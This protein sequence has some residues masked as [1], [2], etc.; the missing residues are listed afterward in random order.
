M[1]HSEPILRSTKSRVV[2]V[3]F[4]L[5]RPLFETAKHLT[6]TATNLPLPFQ[7]ERMASSQ[8]Q[9]ISFASL[10]A[11]IHQ[12]IAA[13]LP[14]HSLM[15]LGGASRWCH[16]FF[17]PLATGRLE[18]TDMPLRD[19]CI[20][21]WGAWKASLARHN[22][23]LTRL[24]RQMPRLY[25]VTLRGRETSLFKYVGVLTIPLLGKFELSPIT[26]YQMRGISFRTINTL[27]VS[28]RASLPRR[29]SLT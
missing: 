10:P 23:S 17:P 2:V 16:A 3:V 15:R 1:T 20:G 6:A 21:P 28:G 19:D 9:A 11:D 22:K 29:L 25:I 27:Y 26:L 18:V 14:A 4:V 13:F 12:A 7:A 5:L 8:A 24:L